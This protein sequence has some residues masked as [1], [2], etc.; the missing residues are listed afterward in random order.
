MQTEKRHPADITTD[1]DILDFMDV[2][3]E[4][5]CRGMGAQRVKALET[6]YG[7]CRRVIQESKKFF[8][9]D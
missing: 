5:L 8:G 6:L 1:Q 4:S 2:H 9:G 7:E 3:F